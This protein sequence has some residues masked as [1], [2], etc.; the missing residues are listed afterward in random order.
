MKK[1]L[2]LIAALL[3]T[4]TTICN[5]EETTP[6]ENSIYI[7]GS[8]GFSTHNQILAIAK[9]EYNRQI[10]G[11][12]FWGA[13]LQNSFGLGRFTTYEVEPTIDGQYYDPYHNTVFQN[14]FM[15]SSMTYYRIPI[16]RKWL[17]LRA[18]AGLGIGYHHIHDHINN[19]A[20]LQDKILPYI[21]AE[22]AWIVKLSKHIDLKFAPTIIGVPQSIS[23][24][25]VELGEPTDVKPIMYDAG[26]NIGL[27]VRF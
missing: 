26:F 15:A 22:L 13:S 9:I 19:P 18:G 12:W 27:G 6:K 11:N 8:T 5:A 16:A 3:F 10:K 20:S 4:S 24:S 23:F 17:S 1:Q 14:I 21:N 2:L 25:P 7:T